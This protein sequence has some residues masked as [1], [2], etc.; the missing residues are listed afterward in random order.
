MTV[1]AFDNILARYAGRT[2]EALL[3]VLWD[4]QTAYGYIGPDAVRAISHTLRVPESDIYGV[5]GFYS[6]FHDEP[7]GDTI[8]RICADPSCGLAG[9]DQVMDGLCERLGIHHGET[10]ADG[11]YRVMH[12]TC[13]GL[14][15]E[16]PAALI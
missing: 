14:C 7:T 9:A 10:T 11:R 3:P 1:L 16:A 13:L 15:A 5:I 8:I 4:V 2:R 6:L 12:T